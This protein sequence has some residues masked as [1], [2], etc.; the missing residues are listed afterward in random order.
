LEGLLWEETKKKI[1]TAGGRIGRGGVRARVTNVREG[2]RKGSD[3]LNWHLEGILLTLY[4][5]GGWRGL[6][7]AYKRR[8]GRENTKADQNPHAW[9]ASVRQ[10]KGKKGVRRS[11]ELYAREE[12]KKA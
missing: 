7:R 6:R 5:T 2:L 11:K 8:G 10:N 9:V 12:A 1:L 4:I 3:R